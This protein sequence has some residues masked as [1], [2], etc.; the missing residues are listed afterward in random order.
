[1]TES[2]DMQKME[3]M[4]EKTMETMETMQKMMDTVNARLDTVIQQN[5]DLAMLGANS[6][7]ELKSLR[8][9]LVKKCL[10]KQVHNS[11]RGLS[12]SDT[13]LLLKTVQSPSMSFFEWIQS[14]Q[15]KEGFMDL[16]KSCDKIEV[17]IFTAL[18]THYRVDDSPIFSVKREKSNFIFDNGAYRLMHDGDMR[19]VIIGFQN[20]AMML[21]EQQHASEMDSDSDSDEIDTQ[22]HFLEKQYAALSEKINKLVLTDPRLVNTMLRKFNTYMLNARGIVF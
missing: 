10:N 22:R 18:K 17:A 13:K 15:K 14:V 20:K 16:V 21:L 11:K 2:S 4:M 6:E 9:L 19:R 1:M 3:K 7:T 8:E 5:K 12:C